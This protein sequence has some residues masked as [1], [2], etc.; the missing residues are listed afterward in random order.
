M[1]KGGS[2][3]RTENLD[4]QQNIRYVKFASGEV[5]FFNFPNPTR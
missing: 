1:Q 5:L 2:G 3:W 4:H